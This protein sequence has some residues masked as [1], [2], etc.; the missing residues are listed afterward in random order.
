MIEKGSWS[1]ELS[2]ELDQME[3]QTVL[4]GFI[5]DISPL[6]IKKSQIKGNVCVIGQGTTFVERALICS[7]GTQFTRLKPEVKIV[8]CCDPAPF[9]SPQ[10]LIDETV[11]A[12]S[13]D[14]PIPKDTERKVIYFPYSSHIL[15]PHFPNAFFDVVL[16][17]RVFELKNQLKSGLFSE[18]DHVLKPGGFFIG[19]GSLPTEGVASFLPP[20]YNLIDQKQLSKLNLPFYPKHI[21]FIIQK[22]S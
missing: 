6:E 9:S 7:P 13:R 10:Y 15:F 11:I 8:V 5:N 3:Y 17:F 4:T 12:L 19:S 16:M 2:E 14:N 21:G 20:G 1:K 22:S 18:I